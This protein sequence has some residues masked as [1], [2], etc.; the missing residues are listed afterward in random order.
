METNPLQRYNKN[1][2]YANFKAKNFSKIEF[3]FYCYG[4]GC[5]LGGL[6]TE[7]VNGHVT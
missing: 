2:T 4:Y 5:A 6:H 3:L 1:C 7:G